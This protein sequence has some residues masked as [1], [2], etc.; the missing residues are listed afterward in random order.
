MIVTSF[1]RELLTY[2]TINGKLV[3]ADTLISGL[4]LPFGGFILL[5]LMC[6]IYRKV[7]SVIRRDSGETGGDGN[8]SGN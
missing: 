6:G 7:R 5:G 3:D 8:V 2:G 4:G 1:H